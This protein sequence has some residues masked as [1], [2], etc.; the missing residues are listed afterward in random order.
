MDDIRKFISKVILGVWAF[1]LIVILILII[2]KQIDLKGGIELLTQ[3]SAVS[4][5]FVGIILG[6]YFTKN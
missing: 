3:F 1:S 6:Y 5:G 2:A 4:S